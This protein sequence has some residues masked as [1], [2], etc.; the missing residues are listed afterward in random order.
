MA[1]EK[2]EVEDTV[3]LAQSFGAEVRM[4]PIAGAFHSRFMEKAVA[5]FREALAKLPCS[6]P[7]IP[8][9]STVTGEYIDPAVTSETLAEHLSS[10]LVTP[11]NVLRDVTRLHDDG[12]QHFLEV[13]PGWSMTR[14]IR[15][16]LEGKPHRAAPSLHPKVGDQETYR[17]ARAFLMA[18]GHLKSAARRRDLPGLFTPDFVEY[19][20]EREP[21]MVALIGEVY[22][23]YQGKVRGDSGLE[24][25]SAPG[26]NSDPR[27]SAE[28]SPAAAAAPA[29]ELP[30]P[31]PT[32]TKASTPG[33]SGGSADVAVWIERLRQ[34]LVDTTGYPAEM[35]EDNLDLEAD[36]GVDSVQQAELWVTLTSAFD[37]PGETRPTS[38][39]T[40]AQ[41]AE[42]LHQLKSGG[43]DGETDSEDVPESA[44]LQAED[45]PPAPTEDG[46]EPG[47]PEVEMAR[48]WAEKVRDRLVEI[49]GYP[50]EM[51][52]DNLDLEA[53]L[54]VDSVQQAEIWMSLTKSAQ[55]DTDKRPRAI[56]TIAQL[57]LELSRLQDEQAAAGSVD[58]EKKKS[59]AEDELEPDNDPGRSRLFVR[60]ASPLPATDLQHSPCG[61]LLLIVAKRDD[62]AAA[63]ERAFC[64]QEI[65]TSLITADEL[66]ALKPE[67][68]QALLAERDTLLYAAHQQAIQRCP[69]EGAAL[70]ELLRKEVDTLYALFRALHPLLSNR[71]LKSARTEPD[72]SSGHRWQGAKRTHTGGTQPTRNTASGVQGPAG[73]VEGDFQQP[74]KLPLQVMVPLAQDGRLGCDEASPGSLLSSF[75][76]GFIRS[77]SRELPGCRFQLL[78]VG[79]ADW[80]EALPAEIQRMTPRLERGVATFGP[81]APNLAEVAPGRERPVPLEKGDQVLV[82]G[83]ARGIVLECMLAMAQRTGCDLVLTGRT[84]PA[85]GSPDWLRTP[86]E[87]MDGVIRAMEL[88]L[89]KT[90]GMNLGQA[91]RA[92]AGARS[93]WEL[94]RNMDRLEA[95]GVG[96][97]YIPCDVA[98]PKAF[99]AL[100]SE[101]SRERPIRGVVIGAGVQRS[102]LMTALTMEAVHLTLDTKLSPLLALMDALPWDDLRVLL[103]FGSVTGLFGN[104]GQTDYG[105]ANDLLAVMLE[106]LGIRH[107][108][109]LVQTVEWTAWTGTGMVTEQ[110][111]KR[112][113]EGGLVPVDIPAGVALFMGALLG[114]QQ[115]RVAAFNPGAAIGEGRPLTPDYPAAPLPRRRLLTVED[116]P[117]LSLHVSNDLFLGEHLV[118]EAPVVPGAFI[119]EI[120]CE[121]LAAL[122]PG[123]IPAQVVFRRP[124][125]LRAQELTLEVVRQDDTLLLMPADR[126][127]LEPKS[128]ANLAFATC[129]P[130]PAKPSA[131]GKLEL[132]AGGVAALRERASGSTPSFYDHLA[133][134]FS[135]ALN[136]GPIFQGIQQAV[137]LEECFYGLVTLT[138]AALALLATPGDFIIN[139]VL[140]DMA[141]Q[142]ASAWG[143]TTHGVLAIPAELEALQVSRPT[144]HRDAVVICKRRSVSDEESLLD[145]AVRE[146]DGQLV[147]ALDGLL[148]KTIARL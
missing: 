33:G 20:E 146:P 25:R 59:V 12:V 79:S 32:A 69:E 129:V 119:T 142:V 10:Q 128:M 1:G 63:L 54:G 13:G 115:P 100:V 91:K 138:D 46:A 140:A 67:E 11:L 51:L 65:D 131:A 36:L 68:L 4:L 21:A 94:A 75:P 73:D 88:N 44:P 99:G 148:L 34:K 125:L 118:N 147:F 106:Q 81:M 41:F 62:Q 64:S 109:L 124:L 22:Q 52:E 93:Q 130:C 28:Q 5:P 108:H 61:G 102:A 97:R 37:I 137:E 139:P 143:V 95:A 14:M 55:L 136:T 70:G 133:D 42:L 92:A 30:A 45:P 60:S 141:V 56:R 47:G 8:I 26:G 120:F 27:W 40:I 71:Q 53:D 105:L 24:R 50:V 82:A 6:S 116:P 134:N 121:A 126:P 78:D 31:E 19:M 113:A 85:E 9:L 43:E 144:G 7:R 104:A 3:E 15:S 127:T 89:V 80:A 29:P 101:L 86:A 74:A 76:A 23:R 66:V 87:E 58:P 135:A 57:A 72:E 132:P 90:E 110:E 107:P 98:D 145:I 96:A 123:L 49:T 17:R 103:G 83:G 112:F 39:R 111:A 16:I 18:L 38:A 114:C 35:L 48:Q 84:A 122:G 77:L 2:K 117:S